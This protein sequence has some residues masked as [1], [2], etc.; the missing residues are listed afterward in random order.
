MIEKEN[1]NFLN[2]NDYII[3]WDIHGVLFEKNIIHWFYLIITYPR[4]F[5][6]IYNLNWKITALLFKYIL[7]KCGMSKKEITNQEFLN[8]AKEGDNDAL[9]ELTL[10]VSCDYYPIWPTIELVKQLHHRGYIQHIGSNIGKDVFDIFRESYKD[11]FALFSYYYLIDTS[12][13]ETIYKKPNKE[14]FIKY[15]KNCNVHPSKIIFIDDRLENVT[16][17]KAC[18]IQSILFTCPKILHQDFEKIGIL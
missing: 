16:A 3:L 13:T 8:S 9:I 11:V 17:A 2:K 7:K 12:D 1:I 15:M 6:V 14:F 4:L 10:R 5:S 18:G